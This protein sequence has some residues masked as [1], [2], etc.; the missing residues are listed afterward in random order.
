MPY[1][2]PGSATEKEDSNA[3]VQNSLEDS[4][5]RRFP[6]GREVAI[7]YTKNKIN[8]A[9]IV[10]DFNSTALAINAPEDVMEEVTAYL[11]LVTKES[12][13][14][15]PS[16]EII[17]S[18]LKN[19]SKVADRYI[20]DSLEKPSRVVEGWVDALFLQ[21]VELKSDPSHINPDFKV[22]IPEKSADTFA[23]VD[24]SELP[25]QQSVV[26]VQSLSEQTP[27]KQEA[28]LPLPAPAK[29]HQSTEF[30]DAQPIG[31][32]LFAETTPVQQALAA[33]QFD[34]SVQNVQAKPVVFNAIE[35]VETQTAAESTQNI[36]TTPLKL[37][38]NS[39]PTPLLQSME[40]IQTR[41]LK[42]IF[43][44]AKNA[45]DPALKMEAFMQVISKAEELGDTR[46]KAAAHF[47]RG[48]IFDKSDMIDSAL[49]EYN[50]ATKSEDNNITAKAHLKMAAIYDDFARFDPAL[51]H[52]HRAVVFAGEANNL[53][54]QSRALGGIA[55]MYAQRYDKENTTAFNGLTVDTALGTDNQKVIGRAYSTVAKNYD[56]L[57][58]NKQSLDSYK[59]A[60]QAF[61]K[62]ENY[63][64]LAQNYFGAAQVMQKLGNSAKADSLLSK[65]LQYQ[66]IA[67]L[68]QSL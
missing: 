22:A 50:Q 43:S 42:Q 57:N 26:P 25:V 65:A 55:T 30:I 16:K 28:A 24:V 68:D 40:N 19:A 14:E 2:A 63:N 29:T 17:F 6:N 61:S 7:D 20:A 48:K 44:L 52:Y 1:R 45:E 31:Q 23:K 27:L 18:N 53:S 11:G 34:T 3:Q 56:Y 38:E 62:T 15:K 59:K 67:Q 39:T 4:K 66:Q 47:E 41:E 32:R 5:N 60:A 8:I 64:K 12:K 37:T 13:K 9:Q 58:E 36:F 10:T 33:Q 49:K 54:G 21:N 51:G 35:Q 46:M